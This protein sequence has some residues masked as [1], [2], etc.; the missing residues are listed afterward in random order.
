MSD[1]RSILL[2]AAAI[3]LMVT[4][5][6]AA[7]QVLTGVISSSGQKLEGV[8]VSAKMEG[9]TITTS[10]YTDEK[11][12]YYFPPLPAG[13]YK[14]WAQA[15]GFETAKSSVDL[16]AGRHQ[17]LHAAANHGCG[18]P[19]SAVAERI[20]A[21]GVAGSNPTGCAHE[22]NLHEQLQLLPS[23]GLRI[24][25]P[26]RRSRL[27]QDHRSDEG[28]RQYRRIPAREVN[29]DHRPQSEAAGGLSFARARA[30]RN[31][32]DVQA[33]SAAN[34]R[35]GAGRLEAVRPS[36]QSGRRRRHRSTTP[37]MAPIGRWA[38]LPRTARCRT[39]AASGSTARSTSP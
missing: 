36:A 27:E 1:L 16:T 5:A 11:G 29:Q 14:V 4:A 39:T 13:K 33:A 31:V 12:A 10:I 19:I 26:F 30:R 25:I 6:H 24:A 37:T 9:S 34:R 20:G 35:S 32:H 22:E 21:R 28:H 7:D 23:Y 18:A 8:T 38:S 15:L 17:D 2:A 3:L